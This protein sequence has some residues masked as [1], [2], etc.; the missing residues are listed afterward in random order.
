MTATAAALSTKAST[1]QL[2]L[3]TV[4]IRWGVAFIMPWVIGFL[5][6]TAGP[7]IASLYLSFTDY[8]LLSGNEAKWV[9]LKNYSDIL[10][11][12]VKTLDDPSQD[13]SQVLDRNY[14]ELGRLGTTVIGAS[15]PDFWIS[16]KVTIT[17]G[18]LALPVGMVAALSLALLLNTRV[19][20]V[21]LFRTLIYSPVMVP[22]VVTAVLFQ[23]LLNRDQG[24]LNGLLKIV[25]VAGPDWLNRV[26]WVMPGLV[27]IGLWTAGSSMIIYLAGLQAI[28]TE[29]Y[30]AAKVDGANGWI[31]FWR[32]TLPMITP[33]ILY[34]L[35]LGLIGTFQYFIIPYVLTNGQ[36][37]PNKAAFFYNLNLYK[38]AFAFGH[39][40]YASALA[41]ILF[42]IVILITVLVFRTS[43]S[44]VFYAGG[45]R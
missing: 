22:S 32:I 43:G 45:K 44:W 39:M 30:E 29:L 19:R 4:E 21:N 7:M 23:Q 38:T 17:F 10:G 33:V 25:G 1:R 12:E 2:A 8:S 13:A 6:F 11:I 26:E 3:R 41:W 31:R 24:W 40:G 28:P 42:L 18:L 16:L 35:V 14:A 15:D 34:D 37:T 27:I 20:G 36:G 5:L 9:G